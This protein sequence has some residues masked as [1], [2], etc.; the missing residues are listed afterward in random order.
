MREDRRYYPWLGFNEC[1]RDDLR[2]V[3]GAIADRRERAAWRRA[4]ASTR[5][6]WLAAWEGGGAT[7]LLGLDDDLGAG[8]APGLGVGYG[9]L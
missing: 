5:P 3:L 4:F 9:A 6:A 8:D 2:I 7:C 1:W